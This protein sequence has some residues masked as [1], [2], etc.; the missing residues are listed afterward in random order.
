MIVRELLATLGLK[1]DSS[2]FKQGDAAVE[3]SKR[4][5]E[6]LTKVSE[7]AGKALK[8]MAAAGAA[9]FVGLGVAAA[10]VGGE[11]E[12]LRASLKT[13]TGSTEAG[14]SAFKK[15]QAFASST[16]FSVK[17]IT[18]A[19]V[20]LKALGLDPSERAL[21][22]YGNTSSAMGKTLS[23]MI[24]AVADASTGEFERL[25]EFG[26]KASSQG[27]QVAFTFQ[28]VTTTVGKN[29]K[30]IQEYLLAIGETKFAG[31]M[32]DQAK[33][34]NG[35]MSNLGDA[36]DSFLDQVAQGGLLDALKEVGREMAGL[37][38]GGDSL[39]QTLGKALGDA[40]RGLWD[41]FKRFIPQIPRLVE[42]FSALVGV[43]VKVVDIGSKIIDAV[44]GPEGLIYVLISL[45][46]AL[47]G[48]QIAMGA[49]STASALGAAGLAG[50]GVAFA[51]IAVTAAG[52]VAI[53]SKYNDEMEKLR[54]YREEL[55]ADNAAQRDATASALR[56]YSAEDLAAARGWATGESRAQVEAEM[57]R[58]ATEQQS[59]TNTEASGL[60]AAT[61]PTS[62]LVDF[63]TRRD[64]NV[65]ELN[66]LARKRR[67]GQQLSPSEKKRMTA[68][69]KEL[70]ITPNT[71]KFKAKKAPKD[72]AAKHELTA[73]ELIAR[74]FGGGV[75]S[76]GRVVNRERAQLG[77][78]INRIENR[79]DPKV[80]VEVKVSQSDGEDGESLARRVA[81]I[82][83]EQI[84]R[85]VLRPGYDHFLGVVG[86]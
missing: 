17:E 40:V 59:R 45:K 85:V 50:M 38:G 2:S 18:S 8:V 33:T 23:D 51:A 56:E 78:T 28:G 47:G 13:V 63:A 74:D 4:K 37:S 64:A 82:A 5:L 6:A 26:I 39:A 65:R 31:A 54:V 34:F 46:A 70:D 71:S 84:E 72:K 57:V 22:S 79:Y 62:M 14:A 35:V 67:K 76:D 3:G 69:Q 75:T 81:A 1:V 7:F 83:N 42:Q 25:K 29:A 41:A 10:R 77:T 53:M 66:L 55:I 36:L 30:E 58:R 44:G 12:S 9:A 43:A 16:P 27:D 21:K 20:K 80:S 11:F 86:A 68:L 15:I 48:V 73:D 60:A 32:D 52:A 61:A 19:F 49:V 24:E